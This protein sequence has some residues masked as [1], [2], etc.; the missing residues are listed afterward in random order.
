MLFSQVRCL[1]TCP[2]IRGLQLAAFSESVAPL[3][4]HIP[5]DPD[6]L[7]VR[8][9]LEPHRNQ[10]AGRVV[11]NNY[12]VL[13]WHAVLEAFK[14]ASTGE[15]FHQGSR[16]GGPRRSH[17]KGWPDI[18]ASFWSTSPCAIDDY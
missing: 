9:S 1:P 2:I 5:L 17:L 10:M 4:R 18:T 12:E 11:R 15:F 16:L 14:Y 6:G 8:C 13:S 7:W 3:R